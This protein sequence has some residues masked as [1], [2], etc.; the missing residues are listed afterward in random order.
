MVLLSLLL[1]L[2][3]VGGLIISRTRSATYGV[4]VVCGTATGI[5]ACWWLLALLQ[6][7]GQ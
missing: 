2:L 5:T 1:I 7:S 3:V 4:G 6:G